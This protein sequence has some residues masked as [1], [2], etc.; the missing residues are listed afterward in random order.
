M[1]QLG[2]SDYREQTRNVGRE[3]LSEG[4]MDQVT[5]SARDMSERDGSI[6]G[7]VVNAVRERPYTTLVV[8]AGLAFAIGAIW[9]IGQR[10][11]PSRL[12]RLR[13]Q[14]PDLPRRDRLELDRLMVHLRH[15]LGRE[16]LERWWH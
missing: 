3:G 11:Q 10:P 12:A 7:E 8:A 16:R 9:K 2:P 1:A 5:T 14:L 6:G 4:I 15:L 13:A